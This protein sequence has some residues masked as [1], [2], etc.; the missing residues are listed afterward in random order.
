MEDEFENVDLDE[1]DPEDLD[2]AELDVEEADLEAGDGDA[3][4]EA[5]EASLEGI[6]EAEADAPVAAA[7]D[8]DDYVRVAL[9]VDEEESTE[10]IA[11]PVAP[12]RPGEFTC[13]GCFLVKHPSQL[14][15]PKRM[16]CTDCA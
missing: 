12:K 6:F 13:A 8:D 10:G 3:E 15:D 16:L 1:A 7:L 4:D 9:G 2:D 5:A 11:V 14:A